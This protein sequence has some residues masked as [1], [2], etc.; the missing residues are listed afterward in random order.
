[1]ERLIE[2]IVSAL[3]LRDESKLHCLHDIP[4]YLA[5]MHVI[6]REKTHSS[7]D[8]EQSHYPH[9][10]ILK[11]ET[12]SDSEATKLKIALMDYAEEVDGAYV[13]RALWTLG[14]FFDPELTGYLREQLR[15]HLDRGEVSR[16]AVSQCIIALDTIGEAILLDRCFDASDHDYN[17]KTAEEYLVRVNADR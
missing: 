17:R 7:A 11:F 1:M 6:L 12:I 9:M 4:R 2:T 13:P 15:I 14:Y 16:K 3:N 8:L 10:E 5:Q